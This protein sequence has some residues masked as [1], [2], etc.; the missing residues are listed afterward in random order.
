MEGSPPL[1]FT[2]ESP[3]EEMRLDLFV[4]CRIPGISRGSVRRLLEKKQVLVEG[5]SQP[6]GFRVRCGQQVVV[7]AAARSE[8]PCPQPEVELEILEE[9]P[10]LVVINKPATM[11][12]HPLV[13]GET[14]TVANAL[15][16]RYPECA[17]ASPMARE[18]GLVHRL[19]WSTSGLLLAARNR[20][21]YGQLRGMFSAGKVV[22]T[23]LALV[24]GE[25]TEPGRIELAIHTMPGDRTRMK[26]V[27][28]GDLLKGQYAESEYA[29]VQSLGEYTLVRVTCRTGRRHQVRVHMAA[30][31]HPLVGDQLYGGPQEEGTDGALLHA[32]HLQLTPR[33]ESFTAPLP[34]DRLQILEQLGAEL[35]LSELAIIE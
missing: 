22:K 9:L 23:Y 2:V 4:R 13:P 6:K 1:E 11:A 21:T 31:G 29:P 33:Q 14:D 25:I 20:Q 34:A 16:A 3:E 7:A 27:M 18:G 12:C 15:V 32:H 26:V 17:A 30:L 24:S 10:D 19:D 8:S 5:R 35:A 28:E